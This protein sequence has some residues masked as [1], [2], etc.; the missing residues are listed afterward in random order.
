MEALIFALPG[1]YVGIAAV[2]FLFIKNS[3]VENI[4]RSLKTKVPQKKVILTRHE[5]SKKHHAEWVDDFKDL[6]MNSNLHQLLSFA[7]VQVGSGYRKTKQWKAVCTCGFEYFDED[8]EYV[9]SRMSR[10]I[11]ES[12]QLELEPVKQTTAPR[13]QIPTKI[14]STREFY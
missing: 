4:V 12:A 10:H 1:G 5:L 8:F 3:R 6:I 14:R 9:E 2:Y 13:I 11:S 7:E